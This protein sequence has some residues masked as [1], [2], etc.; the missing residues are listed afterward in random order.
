VIKN[1]ETDWT[2]ALYPGAIHA[3][4]EAVD[5]AKAIKL[6]SLFSTAHG[7]AEHMLLDISPG[8][9]KLEGARG[10]DPALRPPVPGGALSEQD[11][12]LTG[13]SPRNT[14]YYPASQGL[15]RGRPRQYSM[16]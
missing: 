13:T 11:R 2:M 14:P 15:S 7:A 6:E 16:E 8:D 4:G 9:G 1:S 10:A 3:G 5:V 12:E